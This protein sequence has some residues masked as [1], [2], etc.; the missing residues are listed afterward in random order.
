MHVGKGN[1]DGEWQAQRFNTKM[2][3]A[4]LDVLMSVKTTDGGRLLNS[5]DADD[6]SMIAALGCAFLP[7]RSRSATRRA[8]YIW[9]QLPFS[10]SV[11]N[12]RTLSVRVESCTA[13][14]AKGSQFAERKRLHHTSLLGNEFVVCH[15]RVR[16]GN[17]AASTLTQHQRGCSD[18]L[19]SYITVYQILP[20][21]AFPNTLSGHMLRRR[22]ALLHGVTLTCI[23]SL[24]DLSCEA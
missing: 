9:C 5:L 24:H 19:Y 14:S 12:E 3:F 20:L 4:A 15:V 8:V 21:I 23:S 17:A 1:R 22:G 18:R 7:T 2:P 13:D 11:E 16:R 6:A 10:G